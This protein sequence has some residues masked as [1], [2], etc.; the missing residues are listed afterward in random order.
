MSKF[1]EQESN[2]NEIDLISLF[3]TISREKKFLFI[4][5][6]IATTISIVHSL[7]AK[8]I[9]IGGFN[10]L[11]KEERNI[12]QFNQFSTRK[13]LLNLVSNANKTQILIL[14]SPSLLMPIF[15]E[16][17]NYYSDMGLNNENMTFK[18]WRNSHMNIDFEKGSNVLNLQYKHTDK[19]HILNTL[20]LISTAYQDYSKSITSSRIDRTAKY[21]KEQK[22]ILERNF[23]NSQEKMNRHSIKYGLNNFDG[24]LTL[25]KEKNFIKNS[26]ESNKT[27][28]GSI[29][30]YGNS[31]K[32][33]SSQFNLLEKYESQYLDLSSK[34]K[35]E[36]N[37]Q[38]ILKGKIENLRS[39]LKRPNE[40]LVKHRDLSSQVIR[41][42]KLLKDIDYE[43]QL[44]N[45]EKIKNPY[46]WQL[47]SMPTL[48]EQRI[49]PNRKQQVSLT[50]I[51]SVVIG[52]LL[53]IIKEK[54][55]QIV[56]DFDAIKENISIQFLDTIY[57][58]DL[59]L[60]VKEI[61][62]LFYKNNIAKNK[63]F[64]IISL[65]PNKLKLL[66]NQLNKQYNIIIVDFKEQDI[67]EN[68]VQIL[69]IL[70]SG[71]FTKTELIS[72][73]K[74]SKLYKD[75]ILGWLF[76]DNETTI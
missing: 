25:S 53:A 20:N 15:E 66:E 74:Y 35:E 29:Q 55:N 56:Y 58:S 12:S 71:Q 68:C 69:V 48:E 65:K 73:N 5:T 23:L 26:S 62:N 41:D 11:V 64:G 2:D 49:Y 44:V 10:I 19:N 40:I 27:N 43:L 30:S 45:L 8:P 13:Q 21:L 59:N 47:I 75:K 16:V 3:K 39:A 32:R 22:S 76:L 61:K 72:F 36:S 24:F 1:F 50:F 42:A 9:F 46:P 70:E 7:V 52:S 34:L 17:K 33:Y 28:Q 6:F 31:W 38:K 63:K 60:S 51:V 14:K 57:S 4:F 37:T 67:L 54:R 18:S